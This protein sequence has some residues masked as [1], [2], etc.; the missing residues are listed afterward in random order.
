M[1]V[2]VAGGLTAINW[3]SMPAGDFL[4]ATAKPA[5]A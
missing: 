4:T 1:P 3:I 5:T 2:T